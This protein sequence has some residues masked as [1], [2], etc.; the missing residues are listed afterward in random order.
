M[1]DTT[2][3]VVVTLDC[4]ECQTQILLHPEVA[5]EPCP[6][7]GQPHVMKSTP[8]GARMVDLAIAV[9]NRTHGS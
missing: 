7:C 8:R 2:P 9:H 3:R 6:D 1:T 4:S 5:L